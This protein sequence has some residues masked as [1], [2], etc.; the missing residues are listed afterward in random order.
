M[1][2][3]LEHLCEQVKCEIVGGNPS[4]PMDEWQRDARHYKVQL[5]YKGRRMTLDFWQ[6][7]GINHDPDAEAVLDCLLSDASSADE[8]FELWCGS[9][10]FDTDSRKAE[11]IYRQIRTQTQNLRQLLGDDFDEFLNAER[12]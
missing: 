7:I 6:G 2:A 1:N 11:R 10:G 12:D 5:R 9:L 4:K 8:D 3:T